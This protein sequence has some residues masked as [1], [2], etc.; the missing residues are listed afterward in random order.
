MSSEET[1]DSLEEHA[2]VFSK[3][4]L[5]PKLNTNETGG[6]LENVLS[7]YSYGADCECEHPFGQ[8]AKKGTHGGHDYGKCFC[9]Q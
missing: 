6:L 1:V 8:C 2:A 4:V 3:T 9:I 5:I 7:S